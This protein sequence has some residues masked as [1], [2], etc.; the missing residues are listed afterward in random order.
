MLIDAAGGAV[1]WGA[2]RDEAARELRALLDAKLRG[3]PAA[4]LEPG[5]TYSAAVVRP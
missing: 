1:D 5:W 4:A 3:Q 2:Y